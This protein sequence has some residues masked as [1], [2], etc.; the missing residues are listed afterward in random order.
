MLLGMHPS[1]VGMGELTRFFEHWLLDLPCSCGAPLRECSFWKQ[2]L[3][4]VRQAIP[5][6]SIPQGARLTRGVELA[7]NI[8][9]LALGLGLPN[10]KRY[11]RLWAAMIAAIQELSHTPTLVDS[12]KSAKRIAAR[13]SA[14]AR[15]ANLQVGVIH[16]VRDP[17]AVTWSYLRGNNLRL[18]AGEAGVK[19]GGALRALPSWALSNYRVHLG[20]KTYPAGYIRLRY[21]DFVTSPADE[22]S[23]IGDAF[24]FEVQPLHSVLEERKPL[25]AGHGVAGNRVRRARPVAL[26]MDDEWRHKLPGHARA[27]AALFY[28]LARLY[29]YD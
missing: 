29:G 25:L 15:F 9:P 2:V 4:R 10:G 22:L 8:Y 12:S 13:P 24:G 28:P 17:R 23:R 14:L 5:D 1:M 19:A 3:D 21:E 6:L 26:H 18:E 7:L 11:G 27:L 20:R 16:L